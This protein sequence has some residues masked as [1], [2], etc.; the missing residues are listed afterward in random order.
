MFR[1]L[2]IAVSLIV[3]FIAVAGCSQQMPIAP[4]VATE[5]MVESDN[6]NLI[7]YFQLYI[8]P[9]IPSVEAVPARNVAKHFNVKAYLNPP[10]C[11]DCI[12]IAPL[13]PYEDNVIPLNITLRNPTELTGFDVRGILLSNDPGAYLTNPDDYTTLHDNSSDINPFRAFAKIAN[14]RAFGAGES[15]TEPYS[16]YL[17]KFGKVTVIDYAVD[18]SYPNR[19]VEP[20]EIDEPIVA[21]EIDEGGANLVEITVD[22]VAAE[23][24]VDE[25]RLFASSMGIE[26]DL[27]FVYKEGNT[28]ALNFQNSQ[29]SPAG[30]YSLMIRAGTSGSSLFLYDY[31]DVTVTE[32]TISY[33][34]DIQPIYDAECISCHGDVAPPLGLTLTEGNSHT[35]TVNVDASQAAFKLVSPGEPQFSY[36]F[37]KLTGAHLNF[38]F[39]GSGARMPFDGP[40]YLG[41][42]LTAIIR[43]WIQA[44]ALD[45]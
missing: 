20:I 32:T 34:A 10:N 17:S 29:G 18:A 14:K 30:L 5:R 24:D 38:P 44:G 27:Q 9:S 8:D 40:P 15:F 22:V 3:I 43:D 33:A 26:E 41:I 45:N 13:G 39:D 37:A 2:T 36:L 35:A 12:T 7:G 23:N 19:A 1:N 21:G 4:D 16:V 25:V 6:H 11:D 28:W 42:E 31:F